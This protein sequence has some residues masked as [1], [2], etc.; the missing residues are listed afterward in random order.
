MGGSC[1][2]TPAAGY[3][4]PD[5]FTYTVSDGHGGTDVGTVSVTVAAKV[6]PPAAADVSVVKTPLAPSVAVGNLTGY[7][8]T[9]RN[10]SGVA[11]PAVSVSDPLPAGFRFRDASGNPCVLTGGTLTCSFDLAA[12]ASRQIQ[13][14]G[15][16]VVAGNVTNTAT[17]RSAG[18]PNAGNDGST[19][20]TAVTGKTCTIVG[21]FG[22]DKPCWGR[23]RPT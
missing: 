20:T 13:V 4:G 8:L 18:D 14:N 3:A 6:V 22:D 12:G 1:T 17:V 10:L 15:A 5:S 23:T 9:V 21:T 11:A 7:L 2:Y 19:A 16:F